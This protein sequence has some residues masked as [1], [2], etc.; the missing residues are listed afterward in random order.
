[1]PPEEAEDISPHIRIRINPEQKRDWLEYADNNNLTLTDLVKDSVE[2]TISDDWVLASEAESDFDFGDLD[3]GDLEE[4]MQE[5][6][7]MLQ[8]FETQLDDITVAEST[9]DEELLERHELLPLSER[10]QDQ[11]PEVSDGDALIELGKNVIELHEHQIPWFTGRARDIAKAIDE[12]ENHVRQALIWME[13]EQVSNVSSIIYD[14]ERR[15]YEVNPN[16]TV[17]ET[18]EQLTEDDLPD[19]ADLDFSTAGEF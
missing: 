16:K 19:G 1:M 2:N 5:V 4:D 15:W 18:L 7:S 14:G 12:P 13:S 3:F 9:T 11:L 8:A 17:D 10:V 6:K